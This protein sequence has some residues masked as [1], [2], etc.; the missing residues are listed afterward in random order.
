VVR[1]LAICT[2][3]RRLDEISPQAQEDRHCLLLG[4]AS[5]A[6]RP[7]IAIQ[8]STPL[9]ALVVSRL[10]YGNATLTLVRPQLLQRLQSVVNTAAWLTYSASSKYDSVTPLLCHL[11]WLNHLSGSSSSLLSSCKRIKCLHGAAASYL[12]RQEV[13]YSCSPLTSGLDPDCDRRR[14]LSAAGLHI[15]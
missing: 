7:L 11:R 12:T 1:D 14:C 9:S 15:C 10:D 3:C 2:E 6:K 13:R 5:A 8:T 4:S